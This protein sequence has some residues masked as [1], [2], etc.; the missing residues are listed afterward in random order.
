VS[1]REAVQ[2]DCPYCGER[3]DLLVDCSVGEQEYT[4][5]CAVCCRPI[6]LHV[7]VGEDGGV[8]VAAR[9]EDE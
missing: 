5:D 4:E 9:R 2:I 3:I 1:L 6:L 8:N 7:T